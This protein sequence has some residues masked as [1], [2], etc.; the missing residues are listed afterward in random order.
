M[1]SLDLTQSDDGD[2]QTYGQFWVGEHMFAIPASVLVEV[3]PISVIDPFPSMHPDILGSVRTRGTITPILG[4][5]RLCDLPGEPGDPQAAV[6]LRKGDQSLA[7]GIDRVAGLRRLNARDIQDLADASP[8]DLARSFF[9][10]KGQ[11]VTL[12]NVDALFE[13]SDIPKARPSGRLTRVR[14]HGQRNALPYLTFVSGGVSYAIAVSSLFNTVPRRPLDENGVANDMFLGMLSYLDRSIPVVDTNTALNM[15]VAPSSGLREVV[16]VHVGETHL[17][18]LAVDQILY[19]DYFQPNTVHD[20]PDHLRAATPLIRATRSD[21][22]QNA[23]TLILD[24]EAIRSLPDL[25]DIA[26]MSSQETAAK[27]AADAGGDQEDMIK[28]RERNLVFSAGKQ[29]A[30]PIVDVAQVLHPPEA[31]IP[32]DTALPGLEGLFFHEQRMT[33]LIN[34]ANFIGLS[35]PPDAQEQPDRR[36]L[37][38]GEPETRTGFLVDRV[39]AMS[40]SDWRTNPKARMQDQ[41]DMVHILRGSNDGLLPRLELSHLAAQATEQLRSTTAGQL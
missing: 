12:L 13:G 10:D 31:I 7:L 8:R 32:W 9:L 34:L 20:L 33:P 21:P 22:E 30:A 1:S 2:S 37:V 19:I 40:L 3:L 5:L 15:S 36:V 38:C 11:Q 14:E 16:V 29:F 27:T 24:V 4:V 6:V 26:Q 25:Q 23:Q 28:V 18:G 17:L 39:V 41:F 35:S